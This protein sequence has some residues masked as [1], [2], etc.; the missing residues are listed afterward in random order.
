MTVQ[1]EAGDVWHRVQELLSLLPGADA[2]EVEASVVKASVHTNW[3]SWG[4]KVTVC[5]TEVS[6]GTDVRI[7]SKCSFPLQI[8]DW[9]KNKENVGRVIKGL[10]LPAQS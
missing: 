5:L 6:N 7:S 10:E 4:E 1:A 3:R 9:G 8:I 2:L